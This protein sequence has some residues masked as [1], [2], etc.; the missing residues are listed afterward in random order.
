MRVLFISPELP[1][2][3]HRIRAL[4]L[5]R[6]LRQEGHEVDLISLTHREPKPADLEPLAALCRRADWVVQPLARPLMQS[7]LGLF[8]ASPLEVCYEHSSRL[9]LLLRRGLA[10]R[11]YDVLYV[12]RLRMA[13]YGLAARGLPRVL[14]LSL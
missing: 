4:N 11:S 7:A 6:A 13:E 8:S 2:Q 14:D 9:A 3:F 5:L 10:E 12:K 1:N